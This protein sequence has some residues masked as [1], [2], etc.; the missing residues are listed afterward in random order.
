MITTAPSARLS[1]SLTVTC[2][3]IVGEKGDASEWEGEKE[4]KR[5]KTLLKG[6]ELL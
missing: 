3:E 6:E 5:K 4:K 1:L 2:E